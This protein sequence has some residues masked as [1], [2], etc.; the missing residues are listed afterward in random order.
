[1]SEHLFKYTNLNKDINVFISLP[2]QSN[3]I[4]SY[5]LPLEFVKNNN[6]KLY[7]EL[8][9]ETCTIRTRLYNQDCYDPEQ[10]Y[11]T[12]LLDTK[13]I[14]RTECWGSNRKYWTI[15]KIKLKTDNSY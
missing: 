13:I 4:Q 3:I 5:T 10:N 15:G 6:E 9:K 14:R 11:H 7:R 12:N 1:M 2:K 8:S